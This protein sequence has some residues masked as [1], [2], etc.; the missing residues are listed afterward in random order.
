MVIIS[1][2]AGAAD[3]VEAAAG[4]AEPWLAVGMAAACWQLAVPG[5]LLVHGL[6]L[7]LA[8]EP[9]LLL[10]AAAAETTAAA[11][12]LLRNPQWRPKW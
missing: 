9:E 1:T 11:A 10:F 6:L 7:V 3:L 5:R 12:L 2:A 8:S 4:V